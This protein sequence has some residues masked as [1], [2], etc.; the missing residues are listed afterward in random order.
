MKIVDRKEGR[1]E[2]E[3]LSVE[4]VEAGTLVQFYE[5]GHSFHETLYL[6]A[7]SGVKGYGNKEVLINLSYRGKIF[8]GGGGGEKIFRV[9]PKGT[10]ITLEQE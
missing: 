9:L 6:K 8:F 10:L 3:L 2:F 4:E 5:P 1:E 7:P